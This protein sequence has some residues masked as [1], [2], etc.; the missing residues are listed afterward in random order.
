[1]KGRP[2]RPKKMLSG[3]LEDFVPVPRVAKV[4]GRGR[5]R[6]PGSGRIG[7]TVHISSCQFFIFGDFCAL[8]IFDF[9]SLL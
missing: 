6:P 8:F 9:L 5:G 4:A 2:G 3:I 7:K 1:M